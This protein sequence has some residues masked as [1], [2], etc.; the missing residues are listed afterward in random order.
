MTLDARTVRRIVGELDDSTVASIV[1]TG[2]DE[3]GL[4]EASLRVIE[5]EDVPSLEAHGHPTVRKV[6]QLLELAG[7]DEEPPDEEADIWADA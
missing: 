3:A 5:G 4:R 1:A 7:L 2:I 6:V